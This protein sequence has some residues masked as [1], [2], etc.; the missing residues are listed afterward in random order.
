MDLR[1]D[2]TSEEVEGL[3]IV[4]EICSSDIDP[5]RLIERDTKTHFEILV[6]Q[7]GLKIIVRFHF[8]GGSKKVEIHDA[9]DPTLVELASVS[10]LRK[11]GERIRTSLKK[12]LS[13]K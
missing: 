3:R 7:D 1:V 11:Y 9:A 2:T 6:D 8:F 5:V 4:R 10:D 13:T 12:T